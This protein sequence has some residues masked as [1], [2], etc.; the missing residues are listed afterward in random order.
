MNNIFLPAFI[1]L[2]GQLAI[3]PLGARMFLDLDGKKSEPEGV[4]SAVFLYLTMMYT[5]Y[6]VTSFLTLYWA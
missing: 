6:A 2:V 3:M 5:T 1:G 4:G